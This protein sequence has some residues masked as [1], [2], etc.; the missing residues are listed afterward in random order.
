MELTFS[1]G[2]LGWA[3]LILG[4]GIIGIAWLFISQEASLAEAL[5]VGVAAFIGGFVASEF[6]VGWRGWE[7][8]LDGLA[9]LPAA[10]GGVVI[11]AITAFVAQWALRS[12]EGRA[13]EI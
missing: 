8:L 4:A 13:A 6:V 5:V 11:G 10:I 2:I 9:V 7:P 3:A 1:I 12:R